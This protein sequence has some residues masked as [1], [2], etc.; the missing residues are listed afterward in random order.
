VT[1]RIAPDPHPGATCERHSRNLA[2]IERIETHGLGYERVDDDPNV[3]VLVD[4]MDATSR[5]PATLRLR[6]WEREQ[7]RLVE[8]ERLLDI[9]CGRGEAA[10]ALAEDLGSSG[11]L[12][13]V[14]SSAEMLRVAESNAR[15]V[16]C[17][18]RFRVGDACDLDEPSGSFDAVRSERTLQWIADPLAAIGEIVR[19]VR[20]GGR[21]SLIDTD[22]STLTIDVGDA[23]ITA[24]VRETL[25]T[26]RNRPSNIGRRL[27]ELLTTAGLT[28]V[29]MTDR[30]H[31]WTEWNPDESPA[32]DGC[33]SMESLADDVVDAGQLAPND[34]AAFVD[35]IRAAARRHRFSMRLTMYAVVATA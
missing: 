26:E 23:D 34:R 2:R 13:G 11:E 15:T 17:S 14:D 28:P 9:G 33:F 6:A 3:D 20:P 16:R 27:A 30:T 25:Q 21:V 35:A 29:A 22:W 24:R 32:P 12:V 19:V 18:C 5:W 1:P 31:S 4:A 10:V 7:L 8:G